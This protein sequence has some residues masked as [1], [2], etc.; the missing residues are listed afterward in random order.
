M[1]NRNIWFYIGGSGLDRTDDFKKI[2]RIRTGS[3]SIL[4]DED[5]TR[6]EKFHSPLISG[7]SVEHDP[8]TC[9]KRN[10]WPL[11]H[12]WPVIVSQ[13]FH[14]SEQRNKVWQL[15]FWCVLCE[16][17]HFVRWQVPTTKH[18]TG[19]SFTIENFRA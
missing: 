19:I 4:S 12:F 16:L 14:F 9:V 13:L 3:D 2:L 15:R 8:V 11:R 5:W 7:V 18:R 17:K 6:T 10:S 1:Q